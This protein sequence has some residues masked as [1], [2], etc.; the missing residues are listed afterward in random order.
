MYN[1]HQLHQNKTQTSEH[2]TRVIDADGSVRPAEDTGFRAG[3]SP[4]PFI[5]GTKER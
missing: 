3:Q 5:N 1:N 2:P 4:K